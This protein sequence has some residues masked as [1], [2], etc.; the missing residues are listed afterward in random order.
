MQQFPR[1]AKAAAGRRSAPSRQN[2]QPYFRR[3]HEL[4]NASALTLVF[5]RVPLIHQ[6]EVW[7]LAIFRDEEHQADTMD[8]T[9]V[10]RE[11][12]SQ[13]FANIRYQAL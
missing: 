5:E 1:N 12:L 3:G 8:R 4:L 9:Q 2:N 6:I 11:G 13:A 10:A 7:R